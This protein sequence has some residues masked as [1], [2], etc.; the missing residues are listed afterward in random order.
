MADTGFCITELVM[1]KPPEESE[2][3]VGRKPVNPERAIQGEETKKTERAI[4]WEK[5]TVRERA[6]VN[7]YGLAYYLRNA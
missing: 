1:R 7:I 3:F 4:D 6:Y 2:P 5:T